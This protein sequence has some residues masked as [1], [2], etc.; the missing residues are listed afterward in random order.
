LGIGASGHVLWLAAVLYAFGVSGSFLGLMAWTVDLA[1]PG[2]RSR[3][4]AGFFASYDLAIAFGAFIFGPV[5]DRWG[6]AAMGLGAAA[7]IV[8][9]QLLLYVRQ[10]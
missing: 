2:S 9:A 3:A 8:L 10:R 7:L 6:F 5:Y 4:M 1:P